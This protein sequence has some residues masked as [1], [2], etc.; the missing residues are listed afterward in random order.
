LRAVLDG[1]SVELP[2]AI[3]KMTSLPAA[4]F[5]LADRGVIARGYQA[6]LVAFDRQRV[7]DKADFVNPHQLS[8]GMDYVVV[9]GVVSRA[10]GQS[11]GQRSGRFLAA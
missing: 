4:Q 7:Q 8:E 3:R 1:K 6:D 11:T 9:N 10:A 2:E 5:G